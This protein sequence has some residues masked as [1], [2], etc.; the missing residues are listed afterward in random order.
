ML[1]ASEHASKF[2]VMSNVCQADDHSRKKDSIIAM[3]IIP[4]V[5]YLSGR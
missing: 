5:V 3:K 2:I 4:L 1:I